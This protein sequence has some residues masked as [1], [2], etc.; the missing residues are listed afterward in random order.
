MDRDFQQSFVKP[1]VKLGVY[2][3][4]VDSTGIIL[5]SNPRGLGSIITATIDSRSRETGKQPEKKGE[6][7]KVFFEKSFHVTEILDIPVIK[8]QLALNNPK[9]AS[10]N[11]F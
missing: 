5:K 8:G 11:S 2:A 4:D 10:H 9:R 3:N 7:Y 6:V 1:N